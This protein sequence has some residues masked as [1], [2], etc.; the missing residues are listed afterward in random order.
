MSKRFRHRFNF[1]IYDDTY[2][3]SEIIDYL[4]SHDSGHARQEAIRSLIRAGFS[5]LIKSNDSK[6]AN[7]DS[8]DPSV[9]HA[10]LQTLNNITNSGN[11]YVRAPEPPLNHHV[12]NNESQK[13]EIQYN[14]NN[15]NI[16][17]N[18]SSEPTYREDKINSEIDN[19]DEFKSNIIINKENEFTPRIDESTN[20]MSV[21][22]SFDDNRDLSG[23]I[24]DDDIEDPMALFS[25][26]GG[27]F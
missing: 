8:I 16:V 23:E 20:T 10:A 18:K 26:E 17:K 2:L 12:N 1:S 13:T 15:D 19:K 21:D 7:I 27:L 5:S 3:D 24:E 4:A 14:S 11:S 25:G 6:Q 9:L 22:D